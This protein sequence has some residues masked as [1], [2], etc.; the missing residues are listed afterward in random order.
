MGAFSPFPAAMLGSLYGSKIKI[1]GNGNSNSN[2]SGNGNG[3]GNGSGRRNL[4]RW[5]LPQTQAF[6]RAKTKG[7]V[8]N[9]NAGRS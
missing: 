2:G 3:N 9:R 1:N 7:K 4:P 6:A 8:P 5:C